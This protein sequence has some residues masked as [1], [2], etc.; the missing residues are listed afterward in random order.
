[1]LTSYSHHASNS[2]GALVLMISQ[3]TFCCLFR[4][5]TYLDRAG[6]RCRTFSIIVG[7]RDMLDS[8]RAVPSPVDFVMCSCTSLFHDTDTDSRTNLP[9]DFSSSSSSS[10]PPPPPPP[11]RV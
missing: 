5:K 2:L 7:L 3:C 1:M 9:C 10:P 6:Y 11:P 4:G 8:R